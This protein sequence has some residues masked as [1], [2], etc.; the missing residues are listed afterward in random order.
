[1]LKS[2][3]QKGKRF[4][5]YVRDLIR[6]YGFH[7]ERTPMSGAIH[8]MKGDIMSKNFPF[9]VEVKNTQKTDFISWYK[10]AEQQSRALPPMVVWTRNREDAY[11]FLLFSDFLA[12]LV[13]KHI[14]PIRKPAKVKKLSLDETVNLFAPNLSKKHQARRAKK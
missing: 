11:C 6:G 7:C 2:P 8:F 5:Y 1:M 10:K 14:S 3:S 4:E 13:G 9:F 12:M